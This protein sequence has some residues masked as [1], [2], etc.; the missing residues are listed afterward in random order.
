MGLAVGRQHPL[1]PPV[2]QFSAELRALLIL[3]MT[4]SCSCSVSKS[5]PGSLCPNW[6][7]L[8]GPHSHTVLHRRSKGAQLFTQS[9]GKELGG[10]NIPL[11]DF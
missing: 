11:R 7:V 8:F 1:L 6:Q 10:V 5:G 9:P 4:V 2:S 3:K